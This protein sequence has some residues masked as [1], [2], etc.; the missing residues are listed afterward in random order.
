MAE[1]DVSLLQA[2]M[3]A[4]AAV[5]VYYKLSAELG[6][7]IARLEERYNSLREQLERLGECV[8]CT[9]PAEPE[10]LE[11]REKQQRKRRLDLL[12]ASIA[13]GL[14]V[15]NVY[16][17][18]IAAYLALVS[19]KYRQVYLMMAIIFAA[20]AWFANQ[21]SRQANQGRTGQALAY[22][23]ASTAALAVVL[24]AVAVLR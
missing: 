17:A 10:A 11:S 24:L 18:I 23:A 16:T 2:P 4:V 5:I 7:R 12:L 3:S 8:A 14:L 13:V 9:A 19:A 6:E 22:L 15:A 21:A 20:E 1:I